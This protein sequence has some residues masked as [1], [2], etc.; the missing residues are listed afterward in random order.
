MLTDYTFI[1]PK[2]IDETV[3]ILEKNK[4]RARMIA[5]GT[6]LMIEIRNGGIRF[7]YLVDISMLQEMKYIEKKDG[8]IKIGANMTHDECVN[9]DM[10]KKEAPLLVEACSWIGSPQIRNRGTIGGNIVTAAACA[11]TVPALVALDAR[12]VFLSSGGSR[13]VPVADLITGPYQT[14]IRPDELLTEVS[15]ETPG[16]SVKSAFT[17]LIRRNALA[18]SRLAIA[19]LASKDAKGMIASIR[20]AGGSITPCPCRFYNAEKSLLGNEPS[21]ANFAK[22]AEM[23]TE[24]MIGESGYRWSTEYKKPVVEALIVKALSGV[25]EEAE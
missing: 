21:A 13:E 2:N 16:K 7:D 17:K 9:N 1:R 12:C 15:F 3:S 22:A 11:D 6:D 24:Q 10:L 25:L 20:I 14:G 18:K 23:V 5:G 19:V 4:D 8:K